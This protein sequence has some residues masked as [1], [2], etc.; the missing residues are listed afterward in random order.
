[1][2]SLESVTT[3]PPGDVCQT[4]KNVSCSCGRD[5]A[6][7]CEAQPIKHVGRLCDSLDRSWLM[8]IQDERSE[9][10]RAMV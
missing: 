8:P 9:T 6:G 7:V 5:G 4:E 1:M 2:F 3:S 10:F